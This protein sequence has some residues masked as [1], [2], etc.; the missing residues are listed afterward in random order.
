MMDGELVRAVKL[1]IWNE[2]G[3]L[4]EPESPVIVAERFV[5][6][7]GFEFVVVGQKKPELPLQ[8]GRSP[9]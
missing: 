2:I 5:M 8:S 4:G 6:P 9:L 7:S 1:P 3:L